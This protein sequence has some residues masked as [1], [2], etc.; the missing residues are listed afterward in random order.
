MTIAEWLDIARA[1]AQRRDLPALV[2]ILEGLAKAT[3]A[4]RAGDWNDAAD[5]ETPVD[6]DAAS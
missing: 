2:P 3:E 6:T 1:D 5:G 4:L